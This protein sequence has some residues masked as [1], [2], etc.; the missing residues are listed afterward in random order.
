[1]ASSTG[2]AGVFAIALLAGLAPAPAARA[3]QQATAAA[4]SRWSAWI[5]CWAPAGATESEAGVTLCVVPAADDN[6]AV[7]IITLADRQPVFE[8]RLVADGAP[9]AMAEDGCTGERRA[10]WSADG[11]RLYTHAE[12]RCDGAPTRRAAG[13]SAMVS[14]TT[15]LDLRLATID[16]TPQVR[17]RRYARLF[18]P[19]PAALA[20]APPMPTAIPA[21]GPL[22]PDDVA[23]AH[24]RVGAEATEAWLFESRA[25]LP[26]N[27]RVLRHLSE[28][29]VSER[30]LDFLVARAYPQRFEVRE[31]TRA[32]TT[33]TFEELLWSA[34]D[35]DGDPYAMFY[36]PFDPFFSRYGLWQYAGYVPVVAPPVSSPAP[37]QGRAQVINGVGYTQIVP[38][39]PD[40]TSSPAGG[41][42]AGRSSG[43]SQASVSAGGYAGGGGGT[44]LTAVA[45]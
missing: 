41:A 28:S 9:R 5:G 10:D 17:I 1:M 40:A 38:R 35:G 21:P 37:S 36:A 18:A 29:G 15:W 2:R 7:R 8:D 30:V 27:A 31:P 13:V 42:G 11:D 32:G 14:A 23:E 3:G 6:R 33:W 16:G 39:T 24:Q 43:S 22:T 26:V 34:A 44:G 12:L 25:Q 20:D 45:R 19:W 4:D